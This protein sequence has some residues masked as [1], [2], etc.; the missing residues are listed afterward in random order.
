MVRSALLRPLRRSISVQP[1]LYLPWRQWRRPGTVLTDQT[2]LVIEG[3]PRCA[4]TWVEQVVRHAKP[5]I[6]LAHH[7]HAAAHVIAAVD[8]GIGVLVLHRCPDAAVASRLAHEGDLNP[9]AARTAYLD[10]VA[11]YDRILRIRASD[12]LLWASFDTVTKCPGMLITALNVRFDLHLDA[13]DGPQDMQAIRMRMDA[14]AQ[15]RRGSVR[16][17]SHPEGQ[18]DQRLA[19]R[20]CAEDIV[21]SNAA[22]SARRAALSLWPYLPCDVTQRRAA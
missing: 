2:N 10:Y 19:R 16:S 5:G 6:K 11:F 13:L 21:R 4:N 15:V 8:R 1:W 17:A 3:V 20:A 14:A 18:D 9:A 7:S 22:A 12:H